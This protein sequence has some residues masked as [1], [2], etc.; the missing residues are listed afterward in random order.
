MASSEGLG[1]VADLAITMNAPTIPST[2][3]RRPNIGAS[4]PISD[5]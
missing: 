1:A 5:T 4:A 3:P 2:V